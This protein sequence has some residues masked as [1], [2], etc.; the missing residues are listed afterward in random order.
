MSIVR[1]TFSGLVF[2]QLCQ[3]VLHFQ[4]QDALLTEQ[5]IAE[6]MR[7]FYLNELRLRQSNQ[8]KWINIAVQ[9]VDPA[10]S[11]GVNLPVNI[12]GNAAGA[13]GEQPST[14]CAI[15]KIQTTMMGRAGRGR[16]F[17]PVPEPG[18]Y[19]MGTLTSGA[20]FQWEN[21]ILAMI[22]TRYFLTGGPPITLGV[23][24]KGNPSGWHAAI[25]VNIKTIGGTQRR[26]QIGVGS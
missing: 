14:M 15:I 24:P 3:N 18:H 26:R 10:G 17:V 23:A 4:N 6:E 13:T 20:L 2:G 8:F 19:N 9:T 5:A 21:G 7:D 1:I 12:L 25:S 11:L 16:I 22:R